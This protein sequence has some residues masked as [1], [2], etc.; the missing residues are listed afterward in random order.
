VV[1]T[2]AR[3]FHRD[4]PHGVAQGFQITSHKSEPRSR[5]RNLLS[6]DLCRA[7]LGDKGSPDGP[8]VTFV[9]EASLRAREREGLAGTA[10]C[11]N[12]SSIRPAGETEGDA[13]SADAGKEMALGETVEVAWR[14]VGD[15]SP[16]NDPSGD[17]PFGDEVFEP[18]SSMFVYLV[19]VGGHGFSPHFWMLT[20][21]AVE[22]AVRSRMNLKTTTR[23]ASTFG[24]AL[25]SASQT[26]RGLI[27]T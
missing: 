15:A 18:A 14:D 24:D 6:K 26:K 25:C 13:P 8:E 7:S 11:P 10:S 22:T 9:G 19:V 5:A 21:L 23:M 3:G 27:P 4:C 2:R 16:V 1:R 12:R 17:V 20:A